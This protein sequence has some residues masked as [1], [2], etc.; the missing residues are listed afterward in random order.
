MTALR[1]LEDL[2]L[3][4][5]FR[6]HRPGARRLQRAARGRRRHGRHPPR[7]GAAD[8]PRA[9]RGGG[10]P[11]ALLAPRPAEGRAQSEVHACARSRQSWPSC[12]AGRSHFADDCIGEPAARG[13]GGARKRRRRAA[14]EPALLHGRGEER[15]RLRPRQLAAPAAAYVDDAFGAAHRAHA[16]I[17]GVVEHLP[18]RAAG[19]L[20]VREVEAL[21]RLLGEPERPFAAI[22]GGAKIEGKIDTL[23][24][25]L[26]RLDMLMV[27]GGMANTFL[28]AGGVDMQGSLVEHERLELAARHPAAGC[29]ARRRDA[30]A[31]RPRGRR[32]LRVARAHPHRRRRRDP[33]WLPRARHRPRDAPAL[34]RGG[35]ARPHPVLERPARRLREAPLRRRGRAPSPRRSPTAPAS[36]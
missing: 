26:P 29:R 12:S 34:R 14:R 18:R 27:G 1:T 31:D 2:D 16:S 22:L 23:E 7:R 9:L 36:R 20:M 15:S 33:R 13:G 30:A 21:S 4:H 17:V 32:R 5:A 3:A 6:R 8:D 35:R 25:L 28:A 24:N 11:P 19:R 10:A